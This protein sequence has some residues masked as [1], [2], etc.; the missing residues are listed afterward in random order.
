M[1][2]CSS[3]TAWPQHACRRLHWLPGGADCSGRDHWTFNRELILSPVGR[4][5]ELEMSSIRRS[6]RLDVDRLSPVLMDIGPCRRGLRGRSRARPSS[7]HRPGLRI[8]GNLQDVAG[9][10]RATWM[11]PPISPSSSTFVVFYTVV[12]CLGSSM[13]RWGCATARPRR[14]LPSLCQSFVC[15]HD[16]PVVCWASPFATWHSFGVDEGRES[17]RP[18]FRCWGEA[19][20]VPSPSLVT[21]GDK[22]F[23]D[24]QTCRTTRRATVPE[25]CRDSRQRY[26]PPA[27]RPQTLLSRRTRCKSWAPNSRPSCRQRRHGGVAGEPWRPRQY[28]AWESRLQW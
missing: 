10:V 26:P 15:S 12:Q 3:T 9:V 5:K 6:P 13:A 19:R 28:A 23:H 18:G 4:D 27:R 21:Q 14:H 16:R 20:E 22:I 25:K 7:G 24:M 11:F 1:Q 17:W 2:G 8:A